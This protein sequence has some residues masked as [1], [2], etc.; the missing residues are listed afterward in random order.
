MSRSRVCCGAKYVGKQSVPSHFNINCSKEQNDLRS[1][2][3]VSP[4]T[5]NE[6]EQNKNSPATSKS[7]AR[8]YRPDGPFNPLF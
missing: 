4:V 2:A 3:C 5:I 1:K 6:P 7:S 8:F